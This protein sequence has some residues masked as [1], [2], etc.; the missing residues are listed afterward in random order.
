MTTIIIAT[1]VVWTIFGFFVLF[2]SIE[3]LTYS[4]T[5]LFKLALALGPVIF[6]AGIIGGAFLIA[7]DKTINWLKQN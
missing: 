2:N 5:N 6:F 1:L 3:D 4:K 7:V